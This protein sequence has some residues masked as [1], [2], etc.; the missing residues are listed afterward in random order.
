MSLHLA[1]FGPPYHASNPAAFVLVRMLH[2]QLHP[3]SRHQ[4][5][6][7]SLAAPPP[8]SSLKPNPSRSLPVRPH[9]PRRIVQP[10]PCPLFRPIVPVNREFGPS[11][12]LSIECRRIIELPPCLNHFAAVQPF[13]CRPLLARPSL[14][15]RTSVSI[16]VQPA[17]PALHSTVLTS[18]AGSACCSSPRPVSSSFPVQRL[19]DE[20]GGKR[21]AGASH[22]PMDSN[23]LIALLVL[24]AVCVN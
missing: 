9:P 11:L 5:P 23:N 18:L 6:P 4:L 7:R 3:A 2:P 10:R 21:S 15:L 12:P 13:R 19:C 14:R 1:H 20:N 24:V 16:K 22:F 17:P 8:S